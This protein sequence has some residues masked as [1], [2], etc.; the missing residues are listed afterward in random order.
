MLLQAQQLAELMN[1]HQVSEDNEADMYTMMVPVEETELQPDPESK[2]VKFRYVLSERDYFS[3][4][5]GL[6]DQEHGGQGYMRANCLTLEPPHPDEEDDQSRI[7]MTC[8]D[9]KST[10]LN[11]SHSSVSRMPSSA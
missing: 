4:D 5:G 8:G 1:G 10:R 6:F 11:S 9:R 2:Q 3:A 7:S